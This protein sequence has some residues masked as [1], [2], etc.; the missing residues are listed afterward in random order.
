MNGTPGHGSLLL[1]D[2]AGEKVSYIL[3]KFIEY[4]KTQ[5]EMLENNPEFTIGD[6]TT[7]NICILNGGVQ[8]N[9]VPPQFRIVTDI[10]I[11][12]DVDHVELENTIK[13]WCEEAGEF[14]MGFSK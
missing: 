14:S 5:V 4:R 3:Q 11:A 13:K 7:V 6:V 9:V 2:T 10:R 8:N 12:V 1:K